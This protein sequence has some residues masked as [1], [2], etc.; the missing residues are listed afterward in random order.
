MLSLFSRIGDTDRRDRIF[1]HPRL[2]ILKVSNVTMTRFPS[3]R[4]RYR[5]T[6][7]LEQLTF[8]RCQI[9]PSILRNILSLPIA[10]Q[11]VTLGL[12]TFEM[13]PHSIHGVLESQMGSLKLLDCPWLNSL[14]CNAPPQDWSGFIRLDTLLISEGH[15]HSI[16]SFPEEC[17]M[18]TY[19]P[20]LRALAI[21]SPSPHAPDIDHE[22]LWMTSLLSHL[23]AGRLSHLVNLGFKYTN[24]RT[25]P[26]PGPWFTAEIARFGVAVDRVIH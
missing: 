23:E 10:L 12:E 25:I 15:V 24:A 1:L 14:S 26:D 13:C 8:K 9:S 17:E 21:R 2:K 7:M 20:N 5:K 6:T 19:P 4:K 22:L 3:F 16:A 11:K 18:E